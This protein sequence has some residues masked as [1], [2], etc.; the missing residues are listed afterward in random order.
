MQYFRLA[1]EDSACVFQGVP[2]RMELGPKDMAKNQV[3]VV[4]RDTGEKLVIEDSE[5][6]ANVDRLLEEIQSNLFN[7]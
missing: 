7:K 4:R 2:L 1:S 6:V 5:L 3:V